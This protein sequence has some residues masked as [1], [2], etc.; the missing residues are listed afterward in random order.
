MTRA[1]QKRFVHNLTASIRDEILSKI[2]SG[3]VPEQWDG[4]ELREML[5]QK[6]KYESWYL[7]QTEYKERK[8]AFDN[9]CNMNNL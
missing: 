3:R 1:E 2:K 4:I 6:F 5:A 9:D 8:K 7:Q